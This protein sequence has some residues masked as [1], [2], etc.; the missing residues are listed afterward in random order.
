MT[1]EEVLLLLQ[2]Q[3]LMLKNKALETNTRLQMDWSAK[4]K[5]LQDA[6]KGLNSCDALWIDEQYQSFFNKEI[7]P[8]LKP[9]FPD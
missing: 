8:Y 4:N 1:K 7:R 9:H 3:V 5:V 6:I 2:S